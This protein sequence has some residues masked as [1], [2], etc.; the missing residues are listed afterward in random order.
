MKKKSV[1]MFKKKKKGLV[2][3]GFVLWSPI[4]KVTATNL[5]NI[6]GRGENK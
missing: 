3:K 4:G 6:T 1:G 2:S 5:A